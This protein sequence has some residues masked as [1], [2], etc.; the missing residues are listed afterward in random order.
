M[1]TT[2]P[3]PVLQADHPL[4]AYSEEKQLIL[5]LLEELQKTDPRKEDQKF[6]NIFNQLQTIEKRFERKENQLFLIWKRRDGPV[7]PRGCGPFMMF[8]GHSSGF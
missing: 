5:N 6:Y 1:E 4:K 7:I 8:C 2:A 3:N